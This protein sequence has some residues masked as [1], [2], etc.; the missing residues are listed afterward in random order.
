VGANVNLRVAAAGANRGA[1]RRDFEAASRRLLRDPDLALC[2]AE[3]GAAHR[4]IWIG[5][6]AKTDAALALAVSRRRNL[7]PAGSGRSRPLA[8]ARDGNGDGTTAT[9]RSEGS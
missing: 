1:R 7:D 4:R 3:L 9:F 6:D 8:L 2:N 5:R